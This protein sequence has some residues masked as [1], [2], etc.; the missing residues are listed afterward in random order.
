VHKSSSEAEELKAEEHK[1]PTKVAIEE[2]LA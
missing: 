1:T 2:T